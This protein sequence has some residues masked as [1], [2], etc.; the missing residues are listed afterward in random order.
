MT[1]Q[2]AA[3]GAE[4]WPSVLSEDLRVAA[5]DALESVFADEADVAVER[6]W[7]TATYRVSYAL[8]AKRR[9]FAELCGHRP[10]VERVREVL[11]GDCVVAGCNGIDLHPGGP[12]QALHRDHPVPTPGVTLYLHVVC[13]LDAFTEESGATRVVAGS[14]HDDVTV[15]PDAAARPARPVL[16]PA[17][18]AVAFDGALLHAAGPNRTPGPRRALHLFYA[19]PWVAPHWDLPASIP[20][21]IWSEL[22][23]EQRALL[24]GEARIKR[25]DPTRREVV[26]GVGSR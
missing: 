19:R 1:R 17:G 10:I 22:G 16:A 20:P 15:A 23:A 8:A 6:G 13:A 5:L 11:G 9:L 26:R 7:S 12:A 2:L 4:V 24:G 14:H 18:A 25:F 21:E 3:A